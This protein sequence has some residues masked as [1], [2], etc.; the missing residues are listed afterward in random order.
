[1]FNNA[2]VR[3][4]GP[5]H[6]FRTFFEDKLGRTAVIHPTTRTLC[7]QTRTGIIRYFL[8]N[9]ANLGNLGTL[10]DPHVN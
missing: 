8:Q 9:L 3:M 10:A 6:A 5:C 4:S 7:L 2:N 1:M